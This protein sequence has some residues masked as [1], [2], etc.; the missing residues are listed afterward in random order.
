MIN[1]DLS[2][3]NG[4]DDSIETSVSMKIFRSRE[5]AV[6]AHMAHSQIA[7]IPMSQFTDVANFDSNRLQKTAAEAYPL[8]NRPRGIKDI[9]SVEYHQSQ[10]CIQPIWMTIDENGKY[11]LLDGAHRIVAS[12]INNLE[13]VTAYIF[14]TSPQYSQSPF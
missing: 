13:F 4:A 8:D 1:V 3:M 7:Q 12:Y 6:A 2:F 9:Q 5:Y 14:K 10:I 11:T